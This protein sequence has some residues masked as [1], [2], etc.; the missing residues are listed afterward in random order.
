VTAAAG[1]VALDVAAP[2]GTSLTLTWGSQVDV[3]RI[4]PATAAEVEDE[5]GQIS[6][7]RLAAYI[8]KY[9]TKGTGK[10]EAA[11][12]PIRS[13]LDIDFLKVSPHHRRIIQTAWGPRRPAPI[14]GAEPAAVGAHASGPLPHQVPPLL[15]HRQSHPG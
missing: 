5:N 9:A 1:L 7:Q 13:Q 3:K 15:H 6:E 11:E 4:E 10:T 8:A 12:R 14:R 2:D